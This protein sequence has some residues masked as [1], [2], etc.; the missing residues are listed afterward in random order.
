MNITGTIF[1]PR[2]P[3]TEGALGRNRSDVAAAILDGRLGLAD[4][5]PPAVHGARDHVVLRVV[6]MPVALGRLPRAELAE[7]GLRAMQERDRHPAQ[8]LPRL[9]LELRAVAAPVLQSGLARRLR[10]HGAPGRHDPE[11]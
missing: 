9:R 8:L 11:P 6:A 2:A 1:R 3:E 5:E 7:N 10:E 4:E